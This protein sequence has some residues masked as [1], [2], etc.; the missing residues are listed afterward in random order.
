VHLLPFLLAACS[1][2]DLSEQVS[3]PQGGDDTAPRDTAPAEDDPL[4]CS[5]TLA[6]AAEVP[7]DK[8]CEVAVVNVVD[9]WAVQIEWQW[10]GLSTDSDLDQVM[11]LPVVGNLNDDDGDGLIT[12][13]DIPDIVAIAFDGAEGWTAENVTGIAAPATLVLLES[14]TGAEQWSL[15]GFYWKGGP[16][17]ADVTG[18]GVAEIIA[19]DAERHVVAVSGTGEIIWT[20]DVV[21]DYTYPHV[22]VAD[23]DADGSPE[24][25]ADTLVLD[26]AT[27][28]LEQSFTVPLELMAR[29][30]AAGDLDLDGFQELI[31]G[32]T[33]YSHDGTP[34]WTSDIVGTYGHWVAILDADDD[35]YGEVAMIGNGE[36]AIYDTDGTILSR[37]AAGTDQP[38]PPCVADFD[39][40]GEAE[41]GWASGS[42]FNLYELDG[43]VLWTR[44]ITDETGL[45][46][47]SGY[48]VD[49]DGAYEV[50]YADENT[51]FIFD[52]ASGL[53][54][55]S[56]TGHASGT[57]FEYPIIADVDNDNSAEV[58]MVSNNF[59]HDGI[60]WAGV[61]VLGHA[62][63]GWAA[64]G[65]TWNVHDFAVT[66][67]EQDGT[68]PR[69]PEPSW[70]VY[71]A[72]RSRPAVDAIAV[73]L[74]AEVTDV[75]Y[76]G[77]AP[78]DV[79]R[80][81]VQ[82]FNQG[83]TRARA[84]LPVSLFRRDGPSLSAIGLAYTDDVI[85]PGVGLPGIEMEVRAGWL[86]GADGIEVRADDLGA[87]FGFIGECDE[88]N[89]GG[90]WA[91]LEC[92]GA[93]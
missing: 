80:V 15:P 45:A 83:A 19:F 50:F 20:S 70:Q 46:G 93:P 6:E 78:D 28:A 43:S 31:I 75:C 76:A 71:N 18:D 91:E 89:N 90:Q 49:G 1:E 64:S 40:D 12:E 85:E 39:G 33:L 66:N 4:D 81:A 36:L 69:L 82:V 42:Q 30:P 67:V 35:L 77:C 25:L 60:G 17:I 63:D 11:M 79:V 23:L 14:S 44:A 27:G 87:G 21:V 41:I 58:V 74:Y 61:T 62:E 88:W 72:Y 65:P 55:F 2:Y 32:S 59:R 8:G 34:R 48:D 84:G 24:V 54:N 9:P 7:I 53:T 57:I 16:A 92:G 56:I 52:G 3:D 10:T 22:N 29:M 38:G 86:E 73:D 37:S 68:V 51:F 26:G 13:A 47:C 5:V